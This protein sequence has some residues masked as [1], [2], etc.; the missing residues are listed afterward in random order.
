MAAALPS[1]ALEPIVIAKVTRRLVPLLVACFLAAFLDRVNVSFAALTMNRDLGLSTSAY[2]FGAGIFFLTYFVFEIPSNLLLERFGARLWIARIMFTWGIL[3]AANAFVAGATSLYVVRALLGAAEAGF[4]P[5]IIFYLTLWFPEVYR[6]RIVG[7][8]MTALPLATV[9]GSPVSG[10]LLGLDGVGGL[11]G[12]QWLFIAE[13]LP[14]LVL[15]VVVWR[16]LTD[17]PESA[18]WLD[19]AERRWLVSRLERERRARERRRQFTVAQAL[20]D[21][22]V[23]VLS[24]VYFGLVAGNYGV[25]FFVPQIVKAFGFSNLQ[26]G[27]VAAIPY[28]V[29]ALAMLGWARRSDSAGERRIHTALPLVVTALGLGAAAAGGGATATIAAFGV[30][31]AGIYAAF[32]VFW[33]LP[34][35]FLS[36]AAAAG[37]IALINSI[38]NLSGFVGPYAMGWFKDA[39]G[40]YTIG[41]LVLAALAVA[42][43]ALVLAAVGRPS[44]Q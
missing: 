30:A 42:S 27:F 2:A 33:T 43:A 31:T 20:A 21:P 36:G 10:A 34:T 28:A 9:I 5:G 8:F 39:T 12:W 44:A 16:W 3:S 26:T 14:S 40:S 24:A 18:A 15:S 32:P 41:L 6:A 22:N 4:F 13:A 1:D 19:E 25:T 29:G 7:R 23:L 38:G 17:R 37:G 11:A 35:A